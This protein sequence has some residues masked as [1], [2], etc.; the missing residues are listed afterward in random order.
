M[1]GE[2]GRRSLLATLGAFAALVVVVSGAS[3][4]ASRLRA[5]SDRGTTARHEE[6]AVSPEVL[7][8]LGPL[9][10]GARFG[11][12][13]VVRVDPPRHGRITLEIERDDAAR[14]V[15]DLRAIRLDG[16]QPPAQT[17]KVA[18]FVRG[19]TPQATIAACAALA[20]ALRAREA[21]GHAPPPLAPLPR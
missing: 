2:P 8:Y 6:V 18:I 14:F 16:P 19:P 5:P 9:A 3:L 21:Q 1:K 7:A 11:G 10:G 20:D 15:V 13:R 12:A 4:V 17:E